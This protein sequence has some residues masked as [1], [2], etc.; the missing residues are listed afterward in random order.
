MIGSSIDQMFNAEKLSP[1]Q[2]RQSIENGTLEAYIGI[3]ILQ[4]KLKEQEQPA[5][6]PT[7][8]PPIAEEIMAKASGLDQLQSNLPVERYQEGGIIGAEGFFLTEE[9]PIQKDQEEREYMAALQGLMSAANG[10][11][12]MATIPSKD[13]ASYENST[14]DVE[15]KTIRKPVATETVEQVNVPGGGIADIIKVAAQGQNVPPDL[16]ANI[17]GAESSG[18]NDAANPNSS[19]KGLFQFIDSTWE[20]LG[21]TPDNQFDPEENAQLGAKYTRQNA[22]HLKSELGRNPT[23]GEV[24]AAHFFGPGVSSMLNNADPAD[25]IEAGLETFTSPKGV[26]QILAA[27]PQLQGKTVGEVMQSL[28]NKAG[29]GIVQLAKGGVAHFDSGGSTSFYDDT[30]YGPR[31]RMVGPM[32]PRIAEPSPPTHIGPTGP[33]PPTHIGPVPQEEP[34]PTT[35]FDR[36]I[37]QNYTPIDIY[38]SGPAPEWSIQGLED[39]Y[40]QLEK[41]ADESYKA[42]PVGV[43]MEQTDEERAAAQKAVEEHEAALVKPFKPRETVKA[44]PTPKVEAVDLIEETPEGP[45]LEEELAIINK[46]KENNSPAKNIEKVLNEAEPEEKK[47]QDFYDIF[48]QDYMESKDDRE[49]Q[50]KLDGYLALATAGFAAAAGESPNAL[51]NISKGALAGIQQ[52]GQSSK[53]RSAEEVQG[54]RNLLNAQR[55]KELGETARATQALNASRYRGAQEND[56]KQLLA[57]MEEAMMKEVSENKMLISPEQRQAALAQLRM[58]N[59][60]YQQLF[61]QV[62]GVNYSDT[63]NQTSSNSEYSLVGRRPE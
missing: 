1:D 54:Q 26:E 62:Y 21:G 25:P 37:Q 39:Y 41:K 46:R 4:Q 20:S 52:Y 40:K 31:Q 47:V 16:L 34:S 13:V 57:D 5:Q 45:T 36:Y 56:T 58:T 38:G 8:Q 59:P 27:N 9:D 17:A 49:K 22:E 19:A 51:T 23:Y 11:Q 43:F 18:R 35:P 55:Y 50:K 28:D 3:P 61:K 7:N 30:L 48:I 53:V 32:R 29:E 63:L 33:M 14:P 42:S 15:S 44:K 24:Y 2:I 10:V 12:S 60:T 6:A